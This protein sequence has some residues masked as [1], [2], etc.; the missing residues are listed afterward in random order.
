MIRLF[1][2]D[3]HGRQKD[4]CPDCQE[5][6]TYAVKRLE[7]CPFQAQKPACSRCAIHC[8]V[9]QMQKNITAVMG[10]AGPRMLGRHPLLALRHLWDSRRK[11]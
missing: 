6:L 4:L 3:Q 8:Y 5:L 11:S 9:P 10:Y 2:R 1:C 7:R